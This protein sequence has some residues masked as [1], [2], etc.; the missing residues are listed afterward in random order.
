MPLITLIDPDRQRDIVNALINI[1]QH[2]GYMPDARSGN[3][4]GRTQG[5]SH[6]EV[7]I[8]DAF[9]KGLTG[10]DYEEALRLMLKDADVPPG[11]N[12]EQ[13]GR[14]GL[15]AY[16][17][18]GYVPYGIDRAGTRTVEYAFDDWC[19]AQVAKGL[20]HEQLYQRFMQQ[21]ENWKNLWRDDYEWEGIR[22]FIMPRSATGEWLDSVPM[23]GNSWY[24][25][26]ESRYE[27]RLRVGDQRSGMRGTL[28]ENSFVEGEDGNLVPRTSHLVPRN[29][30]AFGR[31]KFEKL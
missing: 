4:N 31:G 12:E 8:A 27:E 2:D 18:L 29:A 6:A 23:R 15:L 14:G 1:G 3:S 25:N 24:E 16:N 11:G 26:G 21:S 13:E 17:S 19:I 10:I 22:G 7:V 9:V 20:G 5:G 30:K 28:G